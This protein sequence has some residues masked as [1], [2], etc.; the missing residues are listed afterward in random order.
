MRL[1]DADALIKKIEKDKFAY[2]RSDYQAG[3]NDA[4]F[5]ARIVVDNFLIVDA[6]PVI[7]C[8]DCKHWLPHEQF[9]LDEDNG[10]FH[11]YCA[12]LIPEDDYYAFTRE[13]DDFCSR[14]ERKEECGHQ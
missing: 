9:G 12:R 2:I 6:M 3:Y 5:H 4:I 7:R 1:I 11:N 8:K 13:A 10:E 14:A